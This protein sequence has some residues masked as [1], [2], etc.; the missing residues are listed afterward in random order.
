MGTTLYD[1]MYDLVVVCKTGRRRSICCDRLIFVQK[2]RCGVFLCSE[3]VF[4]AGV[5]ILSCD[6][7]HS[8]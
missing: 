1:F 6:E 5:D 2:I 7:S 3:C 4:R 8:L